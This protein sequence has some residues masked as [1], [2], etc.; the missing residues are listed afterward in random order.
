MLVAN[1]GGTIADLYESHE[2]GPAMSLFLWAATVGSPSGYFLFSFVAAT[3]GLRAVFW[4][5]LGICGGFWLLMILTLRETRH[6]VILACRNSQPKHSHL[7]RAR[8]I[9]FAAQNLFQKALKRPFLFLGTEAIVIFSALYNGYLY[10]L[11][12]LFN[13]AF[14]IVFG[15]QG[16][17]FGTIG[18]GL[19]FLGIAIGISIGP[20]TNALF[21][22]PYFQRKLRENNFKNSPEGRVMLGKIA[23]VTFPI[24]LFWFAWTSYS[25]IHWIVPILA[26][27]LWGWS[28]YTLILM[29]YTYTEDSYKVCRLS[30]PQS[31]LSDDWE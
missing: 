9:K 2:T 17:G 7:S 12:F 6:S 13:G 29:T 19:A 24:S 25:S 21:Q 10:G 16:H 5:L 1:F 28:F 4:A 8:R 30:P 26:S 18:V 15:P 23:G 14:N 31:F 3:K 20:I 22:E 11:S 27:A